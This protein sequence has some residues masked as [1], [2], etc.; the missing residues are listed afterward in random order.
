VLV[1]NPPY[2]ADHLQRCLAFCAASRAAWLLLLPSFVHS[3]DYCEAAVAE[4]A[5]KPVYV[6]PKKRFVYWTPKG[7][8]RQNPK[9]RKDGR[10]SPF[11]TLW[12]AFEQLS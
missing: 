3:K 2:S 4:L 10:T 7:A 11:V 9:V 8:A 1:T 6:V 5:H 12:C